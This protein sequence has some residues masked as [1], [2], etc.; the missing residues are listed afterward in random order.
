MLPPPPLRGLAFDLDEEC[1][2]ARHE[3]GNRSFLSFPA[4]YGRNRDTETLAEP[5][6]REPESLGANASELLSR[7]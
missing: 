1:Y 3:L 7:H 5:G 6:L 4:R 2:E